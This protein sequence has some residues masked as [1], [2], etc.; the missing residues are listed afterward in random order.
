MADSAARD[1]VAFSQVYEKGWDALA[2]LAD[3]PSAMRLYVFLAKSC[4]HDNAVVATYSVIS[5]AIGVCERT[6]RRCVR[7]LESDGHVVVLKLGS[8]C[9]YVL[10]PDEVWKTARGHKKYCAFRTQALVDFSTNPTLKRRLTHLYQ[11]RLSLAEDD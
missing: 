4:G 2:A 9:A 8:A 11:G 1:L 5:S 10:N 3:D 7:R 6:I